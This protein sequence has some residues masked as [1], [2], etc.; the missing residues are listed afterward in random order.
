MTDLFGDIKRFLPKYLSEA[1]TKQL[2]EELK[3]FPDNMDGRFYTRQL[4]QEEVVFQ[5]DALKGMIIPNV[6]E[7]RFS[8]PTA[9]LILSNTCDIDA[10]NPRYFR[11]HVCYTPLVS[12]RAYVQMLKEMGKDE[13]YLTNHLRSLKHQEITQVLFLPQGEGLPEDAL[14]FLDRISSCD[15]ELLDLKQLQETRLFSLSNYG[16]YLLLLKLSI[17]FSRLQEKVDR[18]L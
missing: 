12:L 14:V 11:S 6:K 7:R 3:A 2:L 16:F 15:S 13:A 10:Q 18:D 9:A 5:G 1:N 8:E 4:R 17:H